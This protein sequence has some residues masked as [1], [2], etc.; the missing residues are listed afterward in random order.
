MVA[1]G[2]GVGAGILIRN[3]EALEISGKVNTLMVD[4]TRGHTGSHL[5]WCAIAASP[6]MLLQ[7]VAAWSAR[8]NILVPPA[9]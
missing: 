4:K 6:K 5:K 9:S 7:P 3:T 2:R 1:T 8:A